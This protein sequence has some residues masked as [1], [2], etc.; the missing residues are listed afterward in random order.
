MASGKQLSG[1]AGTKD[2]PSSVDPCSI[3]VGVLGK[4]WLVIDDESEE[5]ARLR[6][7]TKEFEA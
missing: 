5:Y 3:S 1:M 2:I 7:G 4:S 6:R